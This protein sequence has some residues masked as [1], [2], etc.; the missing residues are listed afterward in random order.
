MLVLRS[1]TLSPVR[2]GYG[3]KR[4]VVDIQVI[5]EIGVIGDDLIEDF[6]LPVH[7]IHLVHRH[8]QVGNARRLAM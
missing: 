6:L 4:D 1:T 7:Q 2:A 5:A 3:N 8:Y